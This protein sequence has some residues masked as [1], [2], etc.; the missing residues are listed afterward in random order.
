MWPNEF[1]SARRLSASTASLDDRATRRAFA[2][3]SLSHPHI[4]FAGWSRY[5]RRAGRLDP[6]KAGIFAIEDPRGYM[7]ALFRYYVDREPTLA[8]PEM[9]SARVLRLRD[10]VFADLPGVSLLSAIASEG[11][12]L[13]RSMNCDGVTIELPATAKAWPDALAGFNQVSG[14]VVSKRVVAAAALGS[15][16][17]CGRLT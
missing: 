2:L 5:L 16:G 3:V 11:E 10:L 1:L 17:A 13:A 4:G 12:A 15:D 8:A 9:M 7:R 14:S 6:T